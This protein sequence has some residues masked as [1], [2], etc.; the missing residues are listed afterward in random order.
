MRRKKTK[1][2]TPVDF[3]LLENR[4]GAEERQNITA[5]AKEEK[6]R[7]KEE[8]ERDYLLPPPGLWWWNGRRH[9]D[10]NQYSFR[11]ALPEKSS[12]IARSPDEQTPG[13]PEDNSAVW[14][15]SYQKKTFGDYLHQHADIAKPLSTLCRNRE[16][17]QIVFIANQEKKRRSKLFCDSGD[18]WQATRRKKNRYW[19][20]AD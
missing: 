13:Q 14:V 5:Q 8:E 12:N 1:R 11:D 18:Q 10:T 16:S 9:D 2:T 19:G 20:N 15:V 3:R 17:W 7:K 6:E 4:V